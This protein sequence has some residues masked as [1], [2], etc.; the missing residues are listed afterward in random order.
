MEEKV[1]DFLN[2]IPENEQWKLQ[3]DCSKCRRNNYCSKPCTYR[4]RANRAMMNN[5]VAETMDV[6]IGGVMHELIMK[7]Y[8]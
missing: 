4:N 1:G 5:L 8:E 6:M 3:G 2:K 7:K